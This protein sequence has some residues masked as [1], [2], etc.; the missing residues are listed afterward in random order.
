MYKYIMRNSI[1]TWIISATF[2]TMPINMSADVFEK[3]QNDLENQINAELSVALNN[4][5][6]NE[7]TNLYI[8]PRLVVK[9]MLDYFDEEV[10]KY[11]LSPS[12]RAQI[13]PILNSY[14][15]SHCV[16]TIDSNWR[17]KFVLDDKKSFAMMV[18]RVVNIVID[19]M[20]FFVRKIWIPLFFWWNDAIQDKLDHLDVTLMNMKERQ[21]KDVVLDYFA[22]IVKRIA[23]SIDWKVTL[24]EYFRDITHYYPNKNWKHILD[25]LNNSGK[26]N[27]DIKSYKFEKE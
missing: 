3:N 13:I 6:S 26:V 7:V 16:F 5:D 25:D 11:K 27:L 22:W 10:K 18:K 20:P 21:Y 23:I 1:K 8:P 4:S 24:G 2:A 17:M 15:S 14:F 12:A 19:D 9:A